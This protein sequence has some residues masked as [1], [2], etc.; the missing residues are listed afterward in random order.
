MR[1]TAPGSPASASRCA[2]KLMYGLTGGGAARSPNYRL[3]IRLTSTNLQVIVDINTA[4]PDIQNYGID[5]SYTLTDITTGKTVVTGHDFLARV[6]QHSRPAA[7]LRRRPRLARC[8]EPR[9]QGDRG[10]HPLAAGVVFRGGDVE[11]IVLM[12]ERP[13]SAVGNDGAA[14]ETHRFGAPQRW[15]GK[16]K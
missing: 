5:A 1:R 7:A 11:S 15:T 8:R 9:R 13:R 6:L 10:K 3:D 2:T 14:V 12:G 16:A 4:R